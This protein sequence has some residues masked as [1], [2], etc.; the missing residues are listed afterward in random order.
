[1]KQ[2][3]ALFRA[4]F[5]TEQLAK[6]MRSLDR[7]ALVMIMVTWIGAT[8][9]MGVAL[10]TVTIAHKARQQA[11]EAAAVEPIV[12]VTM[13]AIL[14]RAELDKYADRLRLRFDKV[15]FNAMPDNALEISSTE[16]G[17]YLD[18]LAALT[19]LD[20]IAPQVRWSVRDLCVGNECGSGAMMRAA[21][22]GE[23]VTFKVPDAVKSD[24][25][26]VSGKKS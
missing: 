23:R 9:M 12:P 17:N 25:E 7:T 22:V 4:F 18:W 2:T 1:M 14:A 21:L 5:S 3:S 19:Y 24:G 26:D 16:S 13:R 15:T 10:Y 20:T 6:A 8:L 11:D